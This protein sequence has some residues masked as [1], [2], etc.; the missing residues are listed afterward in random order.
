MVSLP[1]GNALILLGRR[2][3]CDKR[4]GQDTEWKY[5]GGSGFALRDAGYYELPR[6]ENG[7]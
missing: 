3:E 5:N 6:L 4:I 7:R 1:A 2:W